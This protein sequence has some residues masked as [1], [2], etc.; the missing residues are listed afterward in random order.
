MLTSFV[1]LELW[2]IGYNIRAKIMVLSIPLEILGEKKENN[3]I[4]TEKQM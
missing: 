2:V 1:K 4:I 3:R